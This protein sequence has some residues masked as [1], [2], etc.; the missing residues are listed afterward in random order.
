MISVIHE[1]F[2]FD[3]KE[4]YGGFQQFGFPFL[5]LFVLLQPKKKKQPP[6]NQSATMSASHSCDDH[7]HSHHHPSH[8][9]RTPMT[10]KDQLEAPEE[11]AESQ[12]DQ[13]FSGAA[14]KPSNV[15]G[16]SERGDLETHEDDHLDEDDDEADEDEDHGDEEGDD[17]ED[18]GDNED[19][20]SGDGEDD[21]DEAAQVR[22]AEDE[23]GS[24]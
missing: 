4:F 24:S 21:E 11:A 7:M 5:S 3:L 9:K 20:P 12:G 16:V 13:N 1:V 18:D 10:S 22:D 8:G 17:D 23:V 14:N 19:D 15:S 6:Q 2:I